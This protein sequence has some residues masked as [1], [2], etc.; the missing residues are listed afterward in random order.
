VRVKE[1]GEVALK[2]SVRRMRPASLAFLRGVVYTVNPAMPWA[3]AVV[4]SGSRIAYVGSDQGAA[5]QIGPS[6]EV[7]DLQG[8][9]LLPGFVDSHCHLAA[10]ATSVD[11]DLPLDQAD[12]QEKLFGMLE[13]YAR[14]HP[15]PGAVYATGWQQFLFPDGPRRQDLDRI[16]G[17]RPVHLVSINSHSS[18][19]SSTA[20][21]LARVDRDTPDP[22]P[23]FSY[24]VRD[25]KGEPTGFI[26]E[27]RASHLVT[28]ALVAV[29]A[30]YLRAALKRWQAPFAAAGLT[31]VYEAGFLALGEEE[32]FQVLREMERAGELFLRVVG[33]HIATPDGA[34][35]DHIRQL[36]ALREV[37]SSDQVRASVL[38]IFLDGVQDNH[39][40]WLLDPYAD[41]PG[42]CGVPNFAPQQFTELVVEADRARVDVHVH[43]IGEASTRHVLDSVAAARRANG[44]WDAR[45]TSCHVFYVHPDDMACFRKLGVIAQT[46]G[47]TILKDEFYEFMQRRIG[48]HRADNTYRLN[49]L[50]KG[51]AT[52]TLGA[53][54]P[55]GSQILTLDPLVQLEI[56]HTRRPLGQKDAPPLPPADECLG[57]PDAIAALTL[58]AARQ[59]RMEDR[60]GSIQVGKLADLVVLDQN[61]FEIPP[62]Q[63]H[64]AQVLLTLMDGRATHRLPF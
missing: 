29:D 6:T 28:D 32:S 62:H 60:I 35:G 63:I 43:A 9:L 27:Y 17:D 1:S 36:L 47:Q 8:R 39:T 3:Q 4:V 38:K 18:W 2:R 14:H 22:Q 24:F 20:L 7:I 64:A 21:S 33:S 13:T 44:W 12:T 61:L 49:S 52:L 46:S 41:M 55:C 5:E 19:A 56:A 59:I 16:F 50:V 26:K 23:S 11:P 31:A 34:A 45:H 57:L 10:G 42:S 15:G 48:R 54:W 58:N 51:G 40:A 37:Y 53:D 25:G 30:A